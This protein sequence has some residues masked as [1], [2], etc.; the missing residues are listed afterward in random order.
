MNERE[1]ALLA[2]R[3]KKTQWM[4]LS[5]DCL[6][7]IGHASG[8]ENGLVSE[9]HRDVFGVKWVVKG[10]P[11]PD[12]NEPV[13]LEDIEEW[14]D[15]VKFPNPKEWNWTAIREAELSGYSGEKVLIWFSEQGMFDRLTV[16]GGFENALC[17]L[18]TDPEET[19]ALMGR[20]ADYKIELIECVGKYI[21]PDVFMYT[22]DLASSSGLFMS[23]EVYREVIKPHHIRIIAAIRKA[24][25]IPEQHTC[26]KC[27]DI[28]P[29]YVEMGIESFFP[30]QTLNDLKGIQEKFGDRLTIV[31]G[32]DSQGAPGRI[33]AP[34]EVVAAEA[35]RVIDDFGERGGFISM[36]M[37][38]DGTVNWT[39]YEPSHRQKIYRD[40]F[41]RYSSEVFEKIEN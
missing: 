19:S 6:Q 27:E 28:I 29:D 36:P 5:Y 40:E 8:N 13:M 4:P 10:D 39:I 9:D 21:K 12:P 31:G 32:Y 25:M 38:M 37:I 23:P 35:R 34:A 16:L 26:G 2:Y 22:D 30:A 20:I 1:N 3:H 24:G 7:H 18:L 17:W 41:R 14:R 33:D 15:I 11:T